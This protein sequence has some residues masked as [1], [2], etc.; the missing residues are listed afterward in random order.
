MDIVAGGDVSTGYLSGIMSSSCWW[1]EQ[2]L[3]A[4]QNETRKF[5]S[6]H[7]S[8]QMQGRAETLLELS[9]HREKN[10]GILM[11]QSCSAGIQRYYK[12]S[13]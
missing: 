12:D 5:L 1:A 4:M 7:N 9:F 13:N 11:A 10:D 6:S 3:V 8:K 2:C